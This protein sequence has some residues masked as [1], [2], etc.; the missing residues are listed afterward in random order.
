MNAAQNSIVS[1]K[2]STIPHETEQALCLPTSIKHP[3]CHWKELTYSDIINFPEAGTKSRCE[4]NYST[5]VLF[6]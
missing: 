5:R 2:F 6:P 3:C 4:L 1:M